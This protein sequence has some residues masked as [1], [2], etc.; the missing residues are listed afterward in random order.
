M[1]KIL[2][3]RLTRW[4]IWFF[5]WRFVINQISR[6]LFVFGILRIFYK[7]IIISKLGSNYLKIESNNSNSF[8]YISRIILMVFFLSYFAY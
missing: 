7:L 1:K 5:W 2:F 4:S 3:R 8:Y 6:L